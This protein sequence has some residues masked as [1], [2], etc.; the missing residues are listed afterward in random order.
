M[1]DEVGGADG[2]VSFDDDA[3][4]NDRSL[5]DSYLRSDHRERTDLD[6]GADLCAWIDNC[7]W[8]SFQVA[9]NYCESPWMAGRASGPLS[10]SRGEG[11]VGVDLARCGSNPSPSSSPLRKGE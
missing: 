7:R 6:I 10:F 2:N 3:R 8:M 9:H 5:S 1:S 11:G 4:L